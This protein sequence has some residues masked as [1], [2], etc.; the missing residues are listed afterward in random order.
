MKA[1]MVMIF[2]CLTSAAALAV[3]KSDMGTK[4]V[5]KQKTS[6]MERVGGDYR[7]AAISSKCSGRSSGPC[8]KM[9]FSAIKKT[10]RF[11]ELVL[12]S[13]HV[14][15]DVRKGDRLRLSAEI[16]VDRGRTAE[17]SQL[18]LFRDEMA[19]ALPVWMLSRKHKAGPAPAA[20]YLEMHVPQTDFRV[21]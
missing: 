2:C 4:E 5:P 3:T 7:L 1:F 19:G 13:N 8:F 16:A 10:G 15:F 9:T 14:N 20:R 18:V 6:R 21:L 12:E 17:V 11:D